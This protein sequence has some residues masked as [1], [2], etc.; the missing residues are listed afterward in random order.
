MHPSPVANAI[1]DANCDEIERQER[2]D[3][4]AEAARIAATRQA[5]IVPELDATPVEARALCV[6][7]GAAFRRF[8]R[9]YICEMRGGRLFDFT[10]DLSGRLATVRG[11]YEDMSIEQAVAAMRKS[12]GDPQD[13]KVSSSGFRSFIWR[14]AGRIVIVTMN[15][16]AAILLVR[17]AK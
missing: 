11:Y 9:G 6:R 7:Q 8:K 17:R 10:P 16:R 12:L 14:R 3:L 13:E 4:A 1:E 15:A 2:G 5:P